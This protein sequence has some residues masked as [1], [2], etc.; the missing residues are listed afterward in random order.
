M[1]ITNCIVAIG[2]CEH[3]LASKNVPAL[4][5]SMMA[6]KY[7]QYKQ[8]ASIPNIQ[9]EKEKKSHQSAKIHFFNL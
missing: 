4:V 2:F 7:H 5:D 6:S 8:N 9:F 1:T 3:G